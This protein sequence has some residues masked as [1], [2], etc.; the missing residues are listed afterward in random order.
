MF[1]YTQEGLMARQM[2][3][4]VSYLDSIDDK[5]AKLN[6]RVRLLT[7]VLGVAIALKH[8]DKINALKN[9]KGE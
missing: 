5:L 6:K 7:V 4:A 9:M 1:N 2:D 3:I 8:K